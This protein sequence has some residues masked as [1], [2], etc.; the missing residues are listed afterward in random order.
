MSAPIGLWHIS[1]GYEKKI[2]ISERGIC[3]GTFDMF[4]LFVC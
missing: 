1:E 4:F 2:S 3:V